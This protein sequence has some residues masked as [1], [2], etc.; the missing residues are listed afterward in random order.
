MVAFFNIFNTFLDNVFTRSVSHKRVGF[1][2][3][4]VVD[5]YLEKVTFAY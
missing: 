1:D 2:S 3:Y 4:L 5:E